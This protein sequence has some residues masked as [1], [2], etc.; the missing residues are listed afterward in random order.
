MDPRLR[1]DD[2]ET[3]S[4]PRCHSRDGGIPSSGHEKTKGMDPR[5]RGDDI[6][7]RPQCFVIP[8]KAGIYLHE[9]KT[10]KT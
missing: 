7:T 2:A 3:A 8:A 6:V 9:M 4:K 10:T 1:G 5:L